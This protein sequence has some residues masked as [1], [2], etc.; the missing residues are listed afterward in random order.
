MAQFGRANNVH[1]EDF[2]MMQ[3]WIRFIHQDTGRFGTL[4]GD[5]ILV[6]EGDIFSTP[7]PTNTTVAL[8]DVRLLI[9]TQPT[10][11]IALWNNFRALGQ[12]L[13]LA[14]PPRAF[15]SNKGPKLVSGPK[16]KNPKAIIRRQS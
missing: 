10:K 12:K 11:V 6:H 8:S 13:N 5:E 3:H 2:T 7:T 15:V 14:I 9:P 16:P 1:K 4:N